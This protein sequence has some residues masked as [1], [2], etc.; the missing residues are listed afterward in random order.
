MQRQFVHLHL[1][2]DCSF[3]EGACPVTRPGR[4]DSA[5]RRRYGDLVTLALEHNSPAVAM[6]DSNSMGGA[7]EFY[8]A[9]RAVNVKPIIGCEIQVAPPDGRGDGPG[10]PPVS[11]YPLVLLTRN[12]EGYGNLCRIVSRAHLHGGTGEPCISRDFLAGHCGGL[13]ALSGCLRGELAVSVLN[14]G[15]E[16]AEKTVHRGAFP[17]IRSSDGRDERCPLSAERSCSCCGASCLSPEAYHFRGSG[18]DAASARVLL[19][20]F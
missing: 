10:D 8:E 1:H 6:T 16:A 14:G 11:G 3:L 9:L 17:Q 20:E 4:A 2:T 12:A 13:I 7:V 18:P 5:E 15:R 19:Q